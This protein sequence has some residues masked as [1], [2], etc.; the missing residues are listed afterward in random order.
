MVLTQECDLDW[1]FKARNGE[2]DQNL[3][4]R[5]LVPNILLSEIMDADRLRQRI[6][7][8]DIWKRIVRNQD[9]RYYFFPPIASTEDLLGQGLPA[10]VVDFKRVFTIPSAELY[11]RMEIGL[12]RR[13]C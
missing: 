6:Q 1:D 2:P 10:L 4:E 8:S 13:A 9:E 3:R 12:R 11:L 5:K 7:G